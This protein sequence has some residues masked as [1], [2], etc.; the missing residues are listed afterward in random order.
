MTTVNTLIT[1]LSFFLPLVH[2]AA[3]VLTHSKLPLFDGLYRSCLEDS[4]LEYGKRDAVRQHICSTQDYVKKLAIDLI[5]YFG[6][7]LFIGKNTIRHGYVTGVATGLVL[8]FVANILPNMFLGISIERITH[9]IGTSNPY[10]YI[11]VGLLLIGILIFVLSV[12][13]RLTQ[14]LTKGIYIDPDDERTIRRR[15]N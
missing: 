5:A 2:E 8:I 13:E 4:L 7:M 10:V 14:E 3:I 12:L 9:A 1:T 15:H 11:A 6:L